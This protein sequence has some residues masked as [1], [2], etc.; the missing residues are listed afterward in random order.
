ML[1]LPNCGIPPYY[2]SWIKDP[3]GRAHLQHFDQVSFPG[4]LPEPVTLVGPAD[5]SLADPAGVTLGCQASENAVAYE[6]LF[7]EDRHD[8]ALVFESASPPSV[9]TGPLPPG[10]TSYWTVRVRDSFGTTIHADD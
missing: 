6:L 2:F 5:G 9:P 1:R 3:E 4:K 10:R 7:G 8:P